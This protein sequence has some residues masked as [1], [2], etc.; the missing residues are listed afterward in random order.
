METTQALANP[1][2]R[3]PFL[4]P[5]QIYPSLWCTFGYPKVQI[6]PANPFLGGYYAYFHHECSS[7]VTG[8]SVDPEAVLLTSSVKMNRGRFRTSNVT[9]ISSSSCDVG[10][11]VLDA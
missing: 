2:T 3:R 7:V 5:R 9:L 4:F 11:G 10:A 8:S 6:D 1:F